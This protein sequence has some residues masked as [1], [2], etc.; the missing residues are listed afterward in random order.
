MLV[1]AP[2][3]RVRWDLL[4]VAGSSRGGSGHVSRLKGLSPRPG[5]CKG[6]ACD[7]GTARMRTNDDQPA[8]VAVR[9]GGCFLLRNG[10]RAS[11]GRAS[12]L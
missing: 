7:S 11:E 9:G 2:S 6:V 3:R 4:S 5:H 8:T 12:G 10:A 1:F